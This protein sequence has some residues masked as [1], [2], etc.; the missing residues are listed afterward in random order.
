[1]KYF[2]RQSATWGKVIQG[3][4]ALLLSATAALG[5]STQS[6]IASDLQSLEQ[7]PEMVKIVVQ[8]SQVPTFAH[9]RQALHYGG[10]QTQQMQHLSFGTYQVPGFALPWLAR[11]HDVV[12]ISLD[13]ALTTSTT[14]NGLASAGLDYHRETLNLPS[15]SKLDGTG[16]GVAVIDSGLAP[17]ADLTSTNIVYS[18]DFTGSGSAVDKYGHGTHVSGIIAGNGVSSTGSQYSYT[19]KGLAPKVNLINLRVLDANGVGTDSEMIAAIDQAI[20]LK[21]TYNIR[22]INLSLGR[23]VFESYTQDPL[24]QAA[25]QAWKAGIVVVAAAGNYGRVNAAGTNGYQTVIAPGNDPYVITVGAMNTQNNAARSQVVPA[26]YSSKGPSLGD[27][28][29]KPDLV[30]PGNMIVSLY[31]SGQT[32]AAEFPGNIVQNSL[33]QTGGSATPSANYI[34]LCGTSMATPMVSGAV[35]LMIQANPSLTPDQVKLRLMSSSYKTLI[36]TSTVKDITTGQS[37]AEEADAFTVGAGYLDVGGA[38]S[39]TVAAPAVGGAMSPVAANDNSGRIVMLGGL[40]SLYSTA[41]LSGTNGQGLPVIA[42]ANAQQLIS[43]LATATSTVQG[44]TVVWGSSA[45]M[46]D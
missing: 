20:S 35:A 8:Y 32:L 15:G 22:V 21:S 30:A 38:L 10:S 24:C 11:E 16:V 42:G 34:A 43:A 1:M 29:V 4:C 9:H 36:P 44:S 5:Q 41:V 23:G 46:A 3:S 6:K 33:Y 14:T 19:F 12:H 26:S 2:E 45:A 13:R 31:Q 40:P 7:S 17:V 18:Q 28:V 37:F 39:S 27:S 25:E